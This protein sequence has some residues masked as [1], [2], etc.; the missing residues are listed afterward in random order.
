MLLSNSVIT[1]YLFLYFQSLWELHT[2]LVYTQYIYM[3]IELVH[4]G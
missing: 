2:K 3:E 1:I 4:G